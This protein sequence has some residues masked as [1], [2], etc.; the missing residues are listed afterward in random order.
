[1]TE[2]HDAAVEAQR[3]HATTG[4]Y[5][6]VAAVLT[7][8]TIFEVGTFYIPQFKPILIPSLLILSAAKFSLVV[9]FYMHLKFDHH[10]FRAVFVLPL[11]IAAAVILGLMFLFRVL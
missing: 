11:A 4:T 6:T 5:L 3:P 10:L 1:M 7:V 2:P 9:M 8:L